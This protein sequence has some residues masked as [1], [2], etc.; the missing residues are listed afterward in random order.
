[1]KIHE[2]QAKQIL[3]EAGVAVPRGY[4]ADT[5]Q[6]AGIRVARSPA[7]MGLTMQTLMKEEAAGGGPADR[8][9]P[10]V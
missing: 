4:V 6:A 10:S 7:E 2:Y 9:P 3:R 5:P 8:R 1:V